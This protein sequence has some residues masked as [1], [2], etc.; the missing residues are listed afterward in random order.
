MSHNK[1]KPNNKDL[2][3]E[4]KSLFNAIDQHI[5]RSKSHDEQIENTM[6]NVAQ[7]LNESISTIEIHSP[8][9]SNSIH[10]SLSFPDNQESKSSHL[11][12]I[13]IDLDLDNLQVPPLIQNNP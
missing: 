9:R 11:N 2:A 5:E 3:S 13:E 8:K 4:I 7:T 10:K 12:D 1:D 6:N